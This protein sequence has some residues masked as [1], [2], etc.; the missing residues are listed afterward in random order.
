MLFSDSFTLGLGMLILGAALIALVAGI[1]L[2][3]RRQQFQAPADVRNLPI[4]TVA[5]DLTLAASGSQVQEAVLVIKPG[6]RLGQ[7]NEI[8]RQWFRVADK[9][10]DLE[11]LANHT[12]PAEAFLGLCARAGQ[13][14]FT[15]DGLLVL[16]VSYKLFQADQPY[17][18]VSL[19]QAQ[20]V[21]LDHTRYPGEQVQLLSDFVCKINI[22]LTL[23]A[24]LQAILE[25]VEQLIP[26]DMV[27]IGLW[28][29]EAQQLKSYR[30]VGLPGVDRRLEET[31][32]NAWMKG[33]LSQKLAAETQVVWIDDLH[34][35]HEVP[36]VPAGENVHF[37]SYLGVPLIDEDILFGTL[38]LMGIQ[39]HHFEAGQRDLL[40]LLASM[41]ARAIK[42]ARL[43]E[44]ERSIA[45]DL[46]GLTDLT[47]ALQDVSDPEVLFSRL[48]DSIYNLLDV[49]VM[50]FLLYDES[51]RLFYGQNPFYGLPP[52]VV[53]WCRTIIQPGSEAEEILTHSELIHTDH[54]GQ[55]SRLEA[56]GL[57][58]VAQAA[59]IREMLL[60]PLSSAGRLVGYLQAA[61][62]RSSS[63]FDQAAIRRL[64]QIAAQVS[65][66]IANA[67]LVREARRRAQRSETLRRIAS[68]T[69]STATLDEI[70]K[71]SMLDLARLLQADVGAILL[72][73]SERG[74][75]R[76][77]WPSLYGI[78]ADRLARLSHFSMD[79]VEFSHTVTGSKHA[80]V[81]SDL[82]QETSLP[83]YQFLADDLQ[84]HSVIIV[85]LITRE[86]GIGELLIASRQPDFYDHSDERSVLTAA[87]QLAA[88]IEQTTLYSQTD[89]N[90]RQRVDQLTAMTRISRDLNSTLDL[91]Y[92]LQRVYDEALRTTAADCGTI[93]LFDLQAAPLEDRL[94]ILHYLGDSMPEEWGG[95]QKWVLQHNE[96]LLVEDYEQ[97]LE[98]YPGTQPAPAENIQPPH[99]GIRSALLAPIAYQGQVAGLIWLHSRSPYAF[100][101]AARQITEALAIQAAIALGNAHRYQEL[102]R[103][104]ELLDRRVE[105]FAR[106]LEISRELRTGESLGDTL[107]AIAYAIQASTPFDMVLISVMD[108]A[109]QQLQR[110][111]GAGIPLNMLAELRSHQQPWQAIHDL[112][113]PEFRQGS[114][115]FIPYEQMPVLP[116]E[117]HSVTYL[118]SLPMTSL[119][120]NW[121][122]DD[123]L[124]V[125]LFSADQ[126]Q[127]LGLVS[128]DA[129]RD[130]RRPDRTA[131]DA[132]E[133]FASQAALAIE[134]RQK[135][136]ALS[137]RV[138]EAE[139]HASQIQVA[140][141]E[142]DRQMPFLLQK[143]LEQTTQMQ[144]L[145]QKLIHFQ[146]AQSVVQVACT[147][148]SR[149]ALLMAAGQEF[150]SRLNYSIVILAESV[151]SG[152]RMIAAL[153]ALPANANPAALLG[154]RNPL[155]HSILTRQVLGEADLL[156]NGEWASSPLLQ[157]LEARSFL[158]LPVI[159]DDQPL[160]GILAISSR[161]QPGLVSQDGAFL[162]LSRQL[163]LF[164]HQIDERQATNQRL[165]EFGT[166]L[167]F[168][169]RLV[170]LD[171]QDVLDTLLASAF[172]VVQEAQAGMIAV[173]DP[174]DGR[175]VPELG[176]GYLDFSSLHKIRINP[177]ETILG[178]TFENRLPAC[179][180]EVEFASHYPFQPHNLLLYR[181]ATGGKPPI[182]SLVIPIATSGQTEAMGIL[183]L[184][185]Y[186]QPQAFSGED[187]ALITTLAQQAALTLENTRLLAE[188]RSLTEDLEKRVALR[189]LELAEEH[190]RTETLLRIITELSASLD[191]D[192][193]LQRTLGVL[194]N[195]LG[196]QKVSIWLARPG[197]AELIRLATLDGDRLLTIN[198]EQEKE[199]LNQVLKG[200]SY[201]RLDDLASAQSDPPIQGAV[202]S[203]LA[204]PL[205]VGADVL[206]TL[207]VYSDQA[208]YFTAGHL[209][210]VRATANQVAVAVNNAELFNL[211]RDQAEGLGGMLREQQIATSRSQA[212]LEAVA[213]GVLVTDSQMK[214][215]LFNASAE[216]ILGLKR[217]QVVG[218]PLEHFSGMFGKAAQAWITTIQNWSHDPA[219]AQVDGAYAEKLELEAGR[220]VEVHLAPVS[221][222]N[223][224]LGT[225]SIFQ[226]ITHQVEVDRLKSEFV[227]TV[228]HELRTPMTSIKGYVEI[229]LMGAAG[230]LG[231][232]QTHFLE[233]VRENTDR[234]TVLVNDLLNISKIESGRIELFP[235]PLD[236][237]SLVSDALLSVE[238]RSAEDDKPIHIRKRFPLNLPQAWGDIERVRQI[239]E[240]LLDNAYLYNIPGGSIEV[241]AHVSGQEIQVD[242]ADTGM[243]I[244]PLDHERIFE[245]FYRG[246]SPLA[247]GV[248]GTGLG[249]SIV[250]S[251][252]QMQGGRIWL[253]SQGVPGKGSTFSFTLPVYNGQ[254]KPAYIANPEGNH[255][256][257][258]LDR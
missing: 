230:E 234:L 201:L 232:K 154:Q 162:G 185:H 224:F 87:G 137:V 151:A 12:H 114:A 25:S 188:T 208:G 82:G 115:Y 247:L 95:Q 231:E 34:T 21:L 150:L 158:S 160:A 58:P 139:Q 43:Y 38:E 36:T 161:P 42:N 79:N 243:G 168:S 73:D 198:A 144:L 138:E 48:M 30:F 3:A 83:L 76:P 77:H 233:V 1:I 173:W 39:P 254:E 112:L 155:I 118:T 186:E 131:I 101:S 68:L 72:L 50:G 159:F 194:N 97:L 235:Q 157:A 63:G 125:P 96:S 120:N 204:M 31:S 199:L 94:P 19:R 111:T 47:R 90:L 209:D 26:A 179:W 129:P 85:P 200:S 4:E 240:N 133:I 134:T 88:A 78:E 93:V 113:K 104:T 171:A 15:L 181:D 9:Q 213:D 14:Q 45:A 52:N 126:S 69:G 91:S 127:P 149:S 32:P 205:M 141:E 103:R 220:I 238:Q 218:K 22:N 67:F 190:Q 174:E 164:F 211:I 8:A 226:D 109:N 176:R 206:G 169:R 116:V 219:G 56:I 51:R 257:K 183:V 175:L 24:T 6:G 80:L 250:Q 178:Q 18:L 146:A 180:A 60:A 255:D 221:L 245:R 2:L 119:E 17:M 152:L 147:Q 37:R 223:D 46:T 61:N 13:A 246:E 49:E 136:A 81:S 29:A 216:S 210:L 248:S 105:T 145:S 44:N 148:P 117:V 16:G 53:D 142:S 244:P 55:D 140:Y 192:Q 242:V 124:L 54:P 35:N 251:L 110:I 197:Q 74:E 92:L 153:G 239:L 241:S 40:L 227:A 122:P 229:L 70:L 237:D 253:E 84:L 135:I 10:P 217:S 212:I 202:R 228:S 177:G 89:Q 182:S 236:L 62:P 225:V 222:R 184:D 75:L 28:D 203:V 132:L 123:M 86:H 20:R 163:G 71:Y 143:D 27:E 33:G 191:L 66:I 98:Q 156:E 193:V 59:A 166:L 170:G 252:V 207:Q 128:V 214:I 130:H 11:R 107:E 64:V 172:S 100:D 65:P 258:D 41:A 5:Q 196:A 256:G 106:L 108:P 165:R 23:E 57:Q 102:F 167:D 189:T 187:M 121:H 215:T 195:F 99:A 7:I 249:L